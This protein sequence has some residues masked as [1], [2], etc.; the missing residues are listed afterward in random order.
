VSEKIELKTRD[1][2]GREWSFKVEQ[3]CGGVSVDRQA[4]DNPFMDSIHF[5]LTCEEA[6]LL[7]CMLERT[8]QP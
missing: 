4:V 6:A 8:L 1:A 2:K 5:L 7:A 3:F